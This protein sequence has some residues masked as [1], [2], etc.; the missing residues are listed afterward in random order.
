MFK[1]T[2]QL[3][4][5][6]TI[7][8]TGCNNKKVTDT[9]KDSKKES[10]VNV[11][12]KKEEKKEVY[13]DDN[14]I[15]VG[16]YENNYKLASTDYYTANVRLKD[17][18][19]ST[20]YTNDETL[21][22]GYMKWKWLQYYNKYTDINNYKIGYNISFDVGDEHYSKNITEITDE[23]IFN[24]YFYVYIYDDINQED[25]SWYSHLTPNDVNDNTIFTSIKL[26]LVESDQITSP[27]T[28]TVFTYDSEDDF[29]EDGQYRGNSKYQININLT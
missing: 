29:D 17:I 20:F 18:V 5:I 15:I 21:M 16:L 13:V 3:L 7:F 19:F 12:V 26:F 9:K 24:P 25:G 27:I 4:L 23:Y 28:L 22:D 14:P 1:K 8:L 6:G 11:P 10:E 2:L